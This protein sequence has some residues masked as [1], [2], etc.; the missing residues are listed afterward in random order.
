NRL[1]FDDKNIERLATLFKTNIQKIIHHTMSRKEKELTPS[2]LGYTG[3]TI[4]ELHRITGTVKRRLGENIKINTMYPLSPMQN[5]ML[6]HHIAGK[7]SGAYFEQTLLNI[8]GELDTGLF[9]E[10]FRILTE[11]HEVL[12]TIFIHEGL[13]KPLQMVLEPIE[14]GQNQDRFLYEDISQIKDKDQMQAYLETMQN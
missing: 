11:R 5:G 12:R 7:N 14:T 13:D 6:F 3:I 2:D 4:E 8:G 9:R 10:S 1:Q